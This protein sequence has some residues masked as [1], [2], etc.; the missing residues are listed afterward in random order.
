[1]Q[2]QWQIQVDTSVMRVFNQLLA[3]AKKVAPEGLA[4]NTIERLKS[5][6]SAATMLVLVDQLLMALQG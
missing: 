6:V 5:P 3:A 2:N 4:V 1:M